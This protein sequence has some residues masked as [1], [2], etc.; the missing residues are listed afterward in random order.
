MWSHSPLVYANLQDIAFQGTPSYPS[1]FYP[2]LCF[3]LEKNCQAQVEP[4][5][6][7]YYLCC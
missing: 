6:T 3:L 1:K 5:S 4:V 7:G 2:G